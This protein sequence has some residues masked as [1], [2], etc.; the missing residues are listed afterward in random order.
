MLKII[1]GVAGVLMIVLGLSE[2]LVT[3][4]VFQQIASR[5]MTAL[6]FIVLGLAG[7]IHA[8][9]QMH[10]AVVVAIRK[11]SGEAEPE[12]SQPKDGKVKDLSSLSPAATS[13]RAGQ[14][15]E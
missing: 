4:T 10:V 7:V 12:A 9:S 14:S 3:T 6:G 11:A 5:L 13:F 2:G 15:P 1:L 8:I